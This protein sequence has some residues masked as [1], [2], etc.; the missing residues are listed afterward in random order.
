LKKTTKLGKRKGEEGRDTSPK[1]GKGEGRHHLKPARPLDP[2]KRPRKRNK[3]GKRKKNPPG[4]EKK[5]TIV[6]S[7][8]ERCS[9][10][11]LRSSQGL[12][13]GG[14]IRTGENKK[15]SC[16]SCCAPGYC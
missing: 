12:K 4:K 14:R 3:K 2:K 8:R 1:G 9:L 15:T 6:F 10:E 16:A 7:P 13:G 5:D 11:S